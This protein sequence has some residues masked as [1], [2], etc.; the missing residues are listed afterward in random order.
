MELQ[1][2]DHVRR[3]PAPDRETAF[4]V[5]PWRMW[6]RLARKENLDFV[7]VES[8]S[9]VG[10]APADVVA[11]RTG[12]PNHDDHAVAR[13]DVD[14]GLRAGVALVGRPLDQ[15]T[16]R[17]GKTTLSRRLFVVVPRVMQCLSL[18]LVMIR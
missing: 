1:L 7:T 2:L 10:R 12:N 15:V 17:D 16:V 13:S 18:S 11:R 5:W 6:I 3:L 4:K 8:R 9:H 14:D